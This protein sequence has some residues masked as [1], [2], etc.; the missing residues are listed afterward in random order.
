VA[1]QSGEAPHHWADPALPRKWAG[2]GSATVTGRSPQGRIWIWKA[3]AHLHKD[4]TVTR[5]AHLRAC[6]RAQLASE[7]RYRS[8][9]GNAIRKSVPLADGSRNK[10]FLELCHGTAKDLQSLFCHSS[11]NRCVCKHQIQVGWWHH[12]MLMKGCW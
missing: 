3:V 12:H 2:L 10:G 9:W 4:I 1:G 7:C 6:D 5:C 11:S 8:C